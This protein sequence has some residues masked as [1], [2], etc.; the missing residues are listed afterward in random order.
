MSERVTFTFPAEIQIVMN[1]HSV[2]GEVTVEQ[3]VV[4]PDQMGEIDRARHFEADNAMSIGIAQMW[5][6]GNAWPT[7]TLSADGVKV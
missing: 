3:S 2:T 6:E 7:P 1:V 4:V 5:L